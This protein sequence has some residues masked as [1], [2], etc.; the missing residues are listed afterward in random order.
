MENRENGQEL[1][2]WRHD[3]LTDLRHLCDLRELAFHE[4]DKMTYQHYS[5]EK[6]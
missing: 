6:R 5:E 4:A 1:K 3:A 2:A